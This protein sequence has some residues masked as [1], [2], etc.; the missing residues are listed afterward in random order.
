MD[1]WLKAWVLNKLKR[2]RYIGGKHTD[3]IN[4]RKGADPKSY[5]EIEDIIKNLVKS[6]NILVKI[7]SYGKHVSLNPR[8]IKEIDEFIQKN[9]T[10]VVF[11]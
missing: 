4:I 11:R 6:G 2:H 3:M 10:E 9:F 7:A 5:S 1:E 8:P